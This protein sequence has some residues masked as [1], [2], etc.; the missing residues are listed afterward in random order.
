MFKVNH[1]ESHPS[2]NSLQIYA[3]FHLQSSD[4]RMAFVSE[5]LYLTSG[6]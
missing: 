5:S 6:E 2:L 1:V 3:A 4:F